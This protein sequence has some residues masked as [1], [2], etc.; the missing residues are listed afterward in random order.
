MG[1]FNS[2]SNLFFIAMIVYVTL[3]AVYGAWSYVSSKKNLLKR[4]DKKL[5]FV[6]SN[7]K[8][9]LPRKFHDIAI[10]KDAIS[11]E[12][13]IKNSKKLS[14]YIRNTNIIYV[15]TLIRKDN[16]TYFTSSSN[17]DT[18]V[19]NND[20]TAYFENYSEASEKT[21]AAFDKNTPTFDTATDRW[22]TFRSVFIPFYSPNGNLYI[23]GADIDTSIINKQ[24]NNFFWNSFII[25]GIFVILVLPFFF[26]QIFAK[27]ER[28]EEFKNLKDMLHHKSMERTLRMEKQIDEYIEK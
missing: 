19:E 6:A 12:L 21:I 7:I 5:I 4:L 9:V 26:I 3:V 13:N 2:K 17:T 18:E 20:L 16:N 8:H 25:S 14:Q 11:N 28:I 27:K 22:G 24:L 23:A 10:D 15:Y 1:R